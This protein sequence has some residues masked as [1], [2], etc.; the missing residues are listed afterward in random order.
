M[1]ISHLQRLRERL[2]IPRPST[3]L[4]RELA[5]RGCRATPERELIVD[6][7]RQ[8]VD[9]PDVDEI[10]RRGQLVRRDLS[11]ATVYRTVKLLTSLGIFVRHRFGTGRSRYEF[12]ASSPHDHLIDIETG[13][14]LEFRDPRL[15]MIQDNLARQMGYEIVSYRLEIF[16]AKRKEI[17]P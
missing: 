2:D 14:I 17:R 11:V 8:A 13:Q 4:R 7:V 12:A 16:A 5:G 1:T 3:D 15:A 6:I 10:H 9:H